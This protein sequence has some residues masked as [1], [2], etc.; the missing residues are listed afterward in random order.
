MYAIDRS[1]EYLEHYG[2]KGMKWG[3]RKAI[4]S[5]DSRKLARAYKKASRKLAKL[6]K[7]ATNGKKYARRAALLGAG[8]AAAG[9]LAAAGTQGVSNAISS[10]GKAIKSALVNGGSAMRR[11]GDAMSARGIRGGGRLSAAG[12]TIRRAGARMD[13]LSGAAN[14]VGKW[15]NS[16]SIGQAAKTAARKGYNVAVSNPMGSKAM[17]SINKQLQG[18]GRKPI[19]GQTD[20]LANISNNTFA[21]IGAGAVGAGLAAGAGY[22]AYRAATTKRAARKAAEFRSEMNKAFKGTQ[23]DTS[24]SSSNK[25]KRRR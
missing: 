14:V 9:G 3:V 19:V 8:A 25:R 1:D 18:S 22:N 21:R 12:R 10:G 5:G 4:E 15:G 13:D 20:K 11:A 24:R 23:Y 6:E 17:A 2:I 7:R 16:N